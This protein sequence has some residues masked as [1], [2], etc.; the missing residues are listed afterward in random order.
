MKILIGTLN[1]ALKLKELNVAQK[2]NADYFVG[3]EGG[4]NNLMIFH[5]ICE[6]KIISLNKS[7]RTE[8]DSADLSG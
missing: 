4:I 8:D 5:S 1:R 2:H 6:I 7:R 3:I